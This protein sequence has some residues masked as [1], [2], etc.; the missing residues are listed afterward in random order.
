MSASSSPIVG[1]PGSSNS[2]LSPR[3]SVKKTRSPGSNAD[4]SS[5]SRAK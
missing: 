4:S 1:P 3:Q 5:C 2:S